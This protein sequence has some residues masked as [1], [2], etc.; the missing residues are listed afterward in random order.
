M[1]IQSSNAIEEDNDKPQVG[2][3]YVAT[4]LLVNWIAETAQSNQSKISHSQEQLGRQNSELLEGE[5]Q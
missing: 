2:T 1:K 4:M 5:Q 3:M